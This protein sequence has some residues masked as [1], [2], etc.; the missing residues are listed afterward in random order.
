[1]KFT[2]KDISRFWSKVNKSEDQ[3]ACW[4][5]QASLQN[6]GYGQF[7]H[8]GRAGSMYLAHRIAW[9]LTNGEIPDGLCVL[10]N[11]PNGDN[12]KC[13]N[14]SHLFL[15]TQLENIKDSINKE[16]Y[17]RGEKQGHHKLTEAQ[18]LA[19]RQQYKIGNI[20]QT[21]LAL[22]F[23]VSRRAI[24]M[25]LNRTNWNYLKDDNE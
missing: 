11:C 19:I 14:P 5:W 1:M 13:V 21:K 7:Q 2:E 3:N 18:V 25:I 17:T 16:R 4:E 20:T 8:G 23:G 15:G 12:P 10:H 24:G 22:D 9:E 6:K